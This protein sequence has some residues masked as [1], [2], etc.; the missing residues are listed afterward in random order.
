MNTGWLIAFCL[1]TVD[2]KLQAWRLAGVSI[3]WH[4]IKTF[5]TNF[6]GK[7]LAF[8]TTYHPKLNPR[9]ICLVTRLS[10]NCHFSTTSVRNRFVTPHLCPLPTGSQQKILIWMARLSLKALVWWS[11]LWYPILTSNNGVMI[12]MTLFLLDG[13][14]RLLT[15][16]VPMSICPFWPVVRRWRLRKRKSSTN[17]CL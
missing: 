8:S 4:I 5:R 3:R 16:S 13:I 17:A 11:V 9:P 10:T 6:G 7:S 12:V 2:M 14:M 1:L 15:I